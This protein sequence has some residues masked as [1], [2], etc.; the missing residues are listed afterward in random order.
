MH[1]KANYFEIHR[2]EVEGF[3]FANGSV[4]VNR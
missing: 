2:G 1:Q 4:Q 3:E